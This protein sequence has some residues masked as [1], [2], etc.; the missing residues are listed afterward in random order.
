VRFQDTTRAKSFDGIDI[1]DIEI[2]SLRTQVAMVN[3]QVVLFNRTVMRQYCLWA[4]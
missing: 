3:Q 2:N 4:V 1:H